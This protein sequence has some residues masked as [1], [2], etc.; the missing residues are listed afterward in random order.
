[1]SELQKFGERKVLKDIDLLIL[2]EVVLN[3]NNGLNLL[4][5]VSLIIPARHG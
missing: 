1:M 4:L 3:T 5:V 2:E